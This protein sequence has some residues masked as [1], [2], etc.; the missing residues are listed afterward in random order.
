[1]D[2]RQAGKWLAIL[3]GV[4]ILALAGQLQ[5]RQQARSQPIAAPQ[6][7]QLEWIEVSVRG[8]VRNP[9]RYQIQ[10][11]KTLREV[12]AQAKPRA[13]AVPPSLPLD[14]PLADGAAIIIEG[15]ASP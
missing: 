7:V 1:M 8:H 2:R 15:P 5:L 6:P 4:V 9:G 3:S 13:G 14:E 11:G 10:R 12:L